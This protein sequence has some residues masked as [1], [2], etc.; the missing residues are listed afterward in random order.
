MVR[1]EYTNW[2]YQKAVDLAKKDKSPDLSL[3]E[4]NL[5]KIRKVMEEK[6]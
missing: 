1:Q 4:E 5:E 6:K 3:Y 2:S